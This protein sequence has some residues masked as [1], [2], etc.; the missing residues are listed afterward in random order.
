[1]KSLLYFSL[2]ANLMALLSTHGVKDLAEHPSLEVYELWKGTQRVVR[3]L[4][5]K[6]LDE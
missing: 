3:G 1:M 4:S 2:M 5:E 6:Y